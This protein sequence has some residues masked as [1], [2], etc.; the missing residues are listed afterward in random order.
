M[1]ELQIR[2]ITIKLE[3][4]VVNMYMSV[5]QC[6]HLPATGSEAVRG[7]RNNELI[8]L[9]V[10]HLTHPPHGGGLLLASAYRE[11]KSSVLTT[12]PHF[13]LPLIAIKGFYIV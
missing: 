12:C 9:G 7:R 13:S 5:A 2:K 6:P 1:L 8:R 11:Y 3:N 10:H 4:T